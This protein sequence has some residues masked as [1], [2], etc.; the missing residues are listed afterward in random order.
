MQIAVLVQNSSVRSLGLG[1][2]YDRKRSRQ[3]P[4]GKARPIAPNVA[5]ITLLPGIRLS[6]PAIPQ[7]EVRL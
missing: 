4:L 1:P 7:V 2:G 3:R 5:A 6:L